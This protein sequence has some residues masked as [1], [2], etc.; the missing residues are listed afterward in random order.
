VL[1]GITTLETN[2][3]AFHV[4]FVEEEDCF[5]GHFP[6]NIVRQILKRKLIFKRHCWKGKSRYS[7]TVLRLCRSM[8]V[9][10]L[11]IYRIVRF[12]GQLSF[13]ISFRVSHSLSC[14]SACTLIIR[15]L[16]L[17]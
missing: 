6:R 17:L 13:P 9:S 14:L 1:E 8:I 5:P 11:R 7:C 2:H 15:F 4:I 10:A 12:C 3:N 16:A